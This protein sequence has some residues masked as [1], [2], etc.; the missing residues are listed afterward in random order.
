MTTTA[1]PIVFDIETEA[2]SEA[3]LEQ[4]MPKEWPLG[5]AKDPEK[6]K[7]IIAEKKKA[8]IDQAALSALT[9][10]VLAIGMYVNETFVLIS[11]P[12]TEAIM[13][14]EFWDAIDSGPGGIH[15]LV[16]FNCK[17]FDLPFLLRRGWKLK[18]LPPKALMDGRPFSRS[19]IDIREVWQA[20]DRQA[21]GSLDTIARHF[22]IG[23]KSMS[24]KDF[25]KTWHE[26]RP[27]A[28]EYLKNDLQLTAGIARAMMLL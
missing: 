17:L 13:I 15:Q 14:H 24:G 10:R 23:Q 7:A 1:H 16:G 2:L 6:V 3:E 18:A 19:I 22:G 20:G 25:A 28:I 21:E 12:A 4:F 26:D 8:W 11:E 5:N 27:A 9:A